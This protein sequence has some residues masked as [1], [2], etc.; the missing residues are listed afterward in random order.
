MRQA[1]SKIGAAV[2][3]GAITPEQALAAQLRQQELLGELAG[4]RGDLQSTAPRIN[5]QGNIESPISTR[6]IPGQLG[7]GRIYRQ[8]KR[9]QTY[10]DALY[11]IL[12]GQEGTANPQ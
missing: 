1:T 6:D 9:D 4:L 8:Q 3:A 5:S 11:R 2:K 12:T 7:F 10:D